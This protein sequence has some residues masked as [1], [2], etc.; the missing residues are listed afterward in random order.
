MATL[1]SDGSLA[2]VREHYELHPAALAAVYS[3]LRIAARLKRT[4]WHRRVAEHPDGAML[5]YLQS[6][7]DRAVGPR[8]VVPVEGGEVGDVEEGC[9]VLAICCSRRDRE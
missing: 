3:E 9:W 2:V 7:N 6:G 4:A 5:G 8:Y 1:G